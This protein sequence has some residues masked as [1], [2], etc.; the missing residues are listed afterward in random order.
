MLHHQNKSKRI[1]FTTFFALSPEL[2][3]ITETSGIMVKANRAWRDTLGY[4]PEFLEGSQ[5]LDLVHSPEKDL[6]LEILHKNLNANGTVAYFEVRMLHNNDSCRDLEWSA[7]RQEDLIY[8]AGRDI[9]E[10][11]KSEVKLL[12]LSKAVEYSP[13]SVIITDTTG[14][15]T[16]VNKKFSEITGFQEEEALG[17]NPNI[18]K[19]GVQDSAFYTDLWSTICSGQSWRGFFHNRKKNGE[20]YWESALIAPIFDKTDTITNYMAV[21]EDVTLQ[22]STEDELRQSNKL[23]DLFF[24]QSLDGFFFMMLDEPLEWNDRIDKDRALDYAFSHQKI[25]RINQAMLDQYGADEKDFIGLTPAD[26]YQHDIEYGKK[27]WRDFFDNGMLHVDTRE[28]KFDGTPMTIEGDYICIY[29]EQGRITGHFGV[30]RDVSF[31]RQAEERLRES[32]ERFRQLA[33]NIDQVFFL[34]TEEKMLYVSPAYERIFGRSCRSLY[35]NPDSYME[36]IHP[37]D[38][39]KVFRWYQDSVQDYDFEYRIVRPDGSER[40][41]WAS[42]FPVQTGD[43]GPQRLA[44]IARDISE[45]KQLEKQIHETSIRDPLTGLYNRRHLFEILGTLG[46]K[47]GRGEESFSL[48]ILDIDHF[49]SINDTYGHVA[50]DLVLKELAQTLSGSIRRY[51]TL[52]RFGGEEFLIVFTGT[53]LVKAHKMMERILARVRDMSVNYEGTAITFT[54]SCGIANSTFCRQQQCDLEKIIADADSKLYR[55][56]RAGRNRIY[57]S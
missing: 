24:R 25:T 40:W 7:H 38:R 32:E 56:K 26:F 29:D 3:C 13:A 14:T 19:S 53:P 12:Q 30:Q 49:K 35:D 54:F 23:L 31:E 46:E 10:R 48:A 37:E 39:E 44:G 11:K 4:E 5:F 22:K 45:R 20:L 34:R 47:A 28:Q 6:I 27:V 55:A 9:T 36:A 17:Q 43:E 21:K 16:Y 1:D 41:I 33:E 52:G 57:S 51:D 42:T 8:A 2:F 15:I 18:L 50:G